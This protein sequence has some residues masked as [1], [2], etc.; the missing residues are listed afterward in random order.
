MQMREWPRVALA[1]VL[2]IGAVLLPTAARGQVT[3]GQ[4]TPPVEKAAGKPADGFYI[5]PSLSVGELYDDNLF[6]SSTD[7][8]QDFF[9]R[10]SPGIQAGYQSTPLMLL[11][12]YTFD[13]EVYSKHP[14]L[15]TIQMRQQSLIQLKAMPTQS[16]TLSARGTF[17]KTRAPWEFNTSTGAAIRRIQADR[18]AVFPSI[19]YQFDPLTRATGD[20]TY[21]KDRIRESITIDSHI[22]RLD[23]DRKIT[24]SDSVGPGYIGRRFEFLG[25]GTLTS[26]APVLSWKR[27][28]TPLTAVALRAGP[29]FT[30]GSLDDRPETVVSIEHQL[31]RGSMALEYSN[32]QST[33]IGVPTI[34]TTESLGGY[35]HYELLPYL[36]VT[37]A[38]AVVKVTAETF[39]T[40]MYFSNVELSYQLTKSLAL[41][42]SH[43]FSVMRG[44]LNPLTGP[45]G[46]DVEIFHNM[47]WL[48]LVATYPYRWQ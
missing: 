27:K 48:R 9:T 39:K 42:G 45:G 30:Q 15:N 20:Y 12:G 19:A 34:A 10:T 22:L 41:K 1:P 35:A 11:G 18:L 13:S 38:P 14:E 36:R 23:L 47:V 16:L 29:R 6:F 4:L 5:T 21:S 24:P 7:P 31:K 28:L 37:I 40:T 3:L 8:K 2:L 17:A 25:V 26:H 32:T 43:Q 44:N 46:A 33:I